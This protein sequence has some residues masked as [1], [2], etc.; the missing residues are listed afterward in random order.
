[1]LNGRGIW[2]FSA[3]LLLGVVVSLAFRSLTTRFDV[4]LAALISMLA[5]PAVLFARGNPDTSL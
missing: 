2:L 4:F 3:F 5:I 1:M